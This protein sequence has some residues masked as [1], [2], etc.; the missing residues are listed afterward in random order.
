MRGTDI[1]AGGEGGA[2]RSGAGTGTYGSGTGAEAGAGTHGSGAGAY[3]GRSGRGSG[4]RGSWPV[5][6]VEVVRS[7]GDLPDGLWRRLAPPHDPMGAPEVF[8]AAERGHVGPDS[9]AYLLL[10]RDE[11]AVGILP[12]SLFSGLRLDDVVGPRERRLL[13]PLRRWAPRL[14]RVPMLFCGNLL[15]QGHLLYDGVPDDEAA[16]LLVRAALDLARRERLGTVVFKDFTP[17]A[18]AA[19]T[20]ALRDA[21]F[22]TV[23]SLPDTELALGYASFEEY[24]AALPA[25]PRRNA[26]SNLRKFEAAGLRMEAVDD[27]APLVPAMLGLYG[28]VMA[29]ADQTLDVLDADFMTALAALTAPGTPPGPA[30]PAAL[31]TPPAPAPSAGADSR[32][33]ACFR[34]ERLVAFLL[35]L[36]AGE[37]AVGARIGLDYAIAH[38]ARLY[39]AV[40]HEAIR[41]ALARGCRHIRFA[42]TAYVPKLEL[43][44]A[45][46]EQTYALTHVRP[47]RRALLRRLLPPALERARAQALSGAH[48]ARPAP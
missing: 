9:H 11:R 32:L 25:K 26:R 29:R 46:V 47:L 34:G 31:G 16:R 2:D 19:L 35:C 44:C 3:G 13:S 36:F 30:P 41:L 27:W 20:R 37:G 17:D 33:V 4:A 5:L 18:P 8:A 40:H 14:L 10:Q 38:E 6:R 23:R 1:G 48:E 15:G 45:L 7:V 24:V 22:F 12:L 39:H 28:Q 21:G 42:Q 43:G